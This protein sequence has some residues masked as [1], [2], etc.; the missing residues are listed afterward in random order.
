MIFLTPESVGNST[1]KYFELAPDADTSL[2]SFC[3]VAF[4][5]TIEER[6]T[7]LNTN[8][9]IGTGQ[10]N[11]NLIVA[12]CGG[13]SGADAANNYTLNG[14]SDWFLPSRD[15]LDAVYNNLKVA[16]LNVFSATDV[17][18]SSSEASATTYY[19]QDVALAYNPAPGKFS[20]EKLSNAFWPVYTR[21][22]RMF[23]VS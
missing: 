17:Y 11:T 10:A 14:Y 18:I 4:A 23:N 12:F 15:E 19:V 5:Q 13:N 8:V 6:T 21:P 7:L 1:G 3:G 22:V 2:F 20:V 16:G 9:E